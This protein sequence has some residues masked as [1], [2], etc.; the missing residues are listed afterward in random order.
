MTYFLKKKK[1]M[2]WV[3]L[4]TF[5]FTS[6][7]P[8]NIL[9][10]NSVA[11]AAGN[12][13]DSPYVYQNHSY[14]PYYQRS[15]HMY[16][17]GYVPAIYI[18]MNSAKNS[19]SLQPKD[20]ALGS[21]N[22]EVT[23]CCDYDTP[24][25]PGT[26]YR[27]LNLEDADYYKEDAAKH[28][29]AITAVA[30]PFVDAQTMVDKM[31][32]AGVTFNDA[33]YNGKD[34]DVGQLLTATQ[35]A[36]WHFA[37]GE[38]VKYS[39][40]HGNPFETGP[41]GIGS[42]LN[43]IR[44]YR[45]VNEGDI[46]YAKVGENI[47]AIY[48]Y[49]I[50]LTP[51][52]E[53]N[54]SNIVISKV[55][56]D[57]YKTGSGTYDVTV[58]VKLNTAVGNQDNIQITATDGQRHTASVS[59]TDMV[60]KS[61][62][63][64]NLSNVAKDATIT[65]NVSGTQHLARG[66][67]F[68]E[69]QGGR[70]TAQCFVGIAEGD[71]PVSASAQFNVADLTKAVEL[72]KYAK[73]N[74]ENTTVPLAGAKFEL[75]KHSNGTEEKI[76]D[77]LTT[78]ADGKIVV[79]M[80]NALES[81]DS[82]YFKEVTAPEGYQKTESNLTVKDGEV[83]VYNEPTEQNSFQLALKKVDAD[84]EEKALSGAKFKLEYKAAENATTY[85]QIGG[86]YTTNAE[87]EIQFND[88]VAGYYQLTETEAPSVD[89]NEK[90]YLQLEEP[91][92]FTIQKDTSGTL[93]LTLDSNSAASYAGNVLT[94]KNSKT[95]TSIS[96]TKT[97]I[98]NNNQDGKRP[99]SITVKLMNGETIVDTKEITPD[100]AGNWTYCFTNLPK[101]ADDGTE[102]EYTISEENVNGYNFSYTKEMKDKINITNTHT[103]E[104]VKLQ[105]KK[106]WSGDETVVKNRPGQVQFT[107]TGKVGNEVVSTKQIV[108]KREGD[109]Q[110]GIE[111][112]PKYSNG[113]EITY[114]ISEEVP[115]GYTVSYEVDGDETVW[116]TDEKVSL[117]K[118]LAAL[119]ETDEDTMESN[120]FVCTVTATNTLQRAG[121]QLV[122]DYIGGKYDTTLPEDDDHAAIFTLTAE[123]S[124]GGEQITLQR[125]G[126]IY[127]TTN[128]ALQY[129]V[130]Y[131]LSEQA[132]AGYV[133]MAD[134]YLKLIQVDG[135]NK[136]VEVDK[137]GE[138]LKA[139]AL[140]DNIAK[141]G[142]VEN[143]LENNRFRVFGEKS[144]VGGTTDSAITLT[145][146]RNNIL[147]ATTTTSLAFD[148][149]Y[150]FDNLPQVDEK[151]KPYV[152]TVIETPIDGFTAYYGS[153]TD[154]DG[155]LQIDIVN[156]KDVLDV[157]PMGAFSVI[158]KT[159]KNDSNTKYGFHLFVKAIKDADSVLGQEQQRTKTLLAEAVSRAEKSAKAA[160]EN[161]TVRQEL[162]EK[163]TFLT[164]TSASFYQ[165]FVTEAGSQNAKWAV[166]TGSAISIEPVDITLDKIEKPSAIW[167]NFADAVQSI[168]KEVEQMAE[169]FT[170]TAD[171]TRPTTETMLTR[172]A[173]NATV[174]SGSA[175]TFE[176]DQLVGMFDAMVAHKQTLVEQKN[177][178]EAF[179]T[180][181]DGLTTPS[182]IVLI[183]NN[184]MEHPIQLDPKS[185]T[186]NEETGLWEFA[187]TSVENRNGTAELA[188]VVYYDDNEK[189]Y[190][191]PFTLLKEGKID[192]HL[193]ATTG[194]SIQYYVEEDAAAKNESGYKR[195]DITTYL[196]YGDNLEKTLRTETAMKTGDWTTLTD[197]VKSEY[198]FYNQYGTDSEEPENPT[199][200]K[201]PEK[202]TK[203]TDPKEPEIP[204]DDS[205]VPLDGSEVQID[206]PN[207]PLTTVPGDEIE[208]EQPIPLGDAPKT[209]DANNAIPFVVLMMMAGLGLVVTR[210]KF[211]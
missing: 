44:S 72:V 112:F 114:Y 51:V 79:Y 115:E 62:F 176:E 117:L 73:I 135:E 185:G 119:L 149:K 170:Q 191:I 203:P 193:K 200:P 38:T 98:D 53:T 58:T 108:V 32:K 93:T 10:G 142:T 81:G 4:L 196:Y 160:L 11:E 168:M 169:E 143:S 133:P 80:D 111:A 187:V 178:L 180:F 141:L 201:E 184:D 109:W 151:G 49:L 162:F 194:S 78:D 120:D 188:E 94:V 110:S 157:A 97:W 65:I 48:D 18:L 103:T 202:P 91:I 66:V 104:V 52:P 161:L 137:D 189:M 55:K 76:Y 31:R 198:E 37:N 121:I 14:Y 39:N 206:D 75:W 82:L 25:I 69:P 190:I 132:P 16:N 205:D 131:T 85:Q 29:R 7:M 28:I 134:K 152:Y 47:K 2:A 204:I 159:N 13:S 17:N 177:A 199:D 211:N 145:L 84:N 150:C 57:A 63:T 61:V 181:K 118:T 175:I 8:S 3:V 19:G 59:P 23:Y 89:S 92:Q 174:T 40:T 128:G 35:F 105:L 1:W 106:E 56:Y 64:L 100:A 102:I 88:L 182:A 15:P 165:F 70:D 154:K 148:W 95:K 21:S 60:G 54:A 99:E 12:A 164:S 27:R 96:G 20:Y 136:V 209:G 43:P 101:Y 124:A 166:T 195:T 125:Q 90:V 208:M 130:L 9:A 197:S 207:V 71:T 86:E 122:K 155:N 46:T 5:L 68:Y 127:A 87:G 140:K 186:Y 210:R 41:G 42:V 26:M 36:I 171:A 107:V 167:E 156:V 123:E 113:K 50:H 173:Q 179:K 144:W 83:T 172:I 45:G 192:F 153:T 139:Y 30:Y 6:F 183:V 33:F 77:N 147:Q 158:K 129:N 74:D 67:Y 34:I 24:A 138:L 163:K 146:Y 22:Y 116:K 126:S